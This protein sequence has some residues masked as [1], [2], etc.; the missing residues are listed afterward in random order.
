MHAFMME[1]GTPLGASRDGH[2]VTHAV[3]HPAV[4]RLAS[5]DE[6]GLWPSPVCTR[7]L[8][9]ALITGAVFISSHRR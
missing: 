4:A 8:W 9:L 3:V 2:R 7:T 5:E 1:R 6:T